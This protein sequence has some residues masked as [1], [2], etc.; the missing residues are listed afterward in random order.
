M[1]LLPWYI[2]AKS[3]GFE[4]HG[5]LMGVDYLVRGIIIYT[6]RYSYISKIDMRRDV[7]SHYC[8]ARGARV[9]VS[10]YGLQVIKLIIM[11]KGAALY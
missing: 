8:H 5:S 4:R 11:E 3:A 10:D 9:Q 6:S 2:P 1:Y 7:Q